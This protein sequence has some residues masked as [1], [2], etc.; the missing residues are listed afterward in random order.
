MSIS[1]LDLICSLIYA[2]KDQYPI[3]YTSV[4]RGLMILN[5]ALK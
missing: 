4:Y 1:E 5:H 2:D 3:R